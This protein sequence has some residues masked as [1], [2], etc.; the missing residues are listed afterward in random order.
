MFAGGE[1][2][3]Q[4]FLCGLKLE[5]R[6]STTPVVSSATATVSHVWVISG[7]TEEARIPRRFWAGSLPGFMRSSAV[8][9]RK[10][11]ASV[12]RMV[13]MVPQI[14]RSIPVPFSFL[15]PPSL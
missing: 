13:K 12:A 1:G 9:L 8:C 10:N 4:E 11:M 3:V 2:L 14:I 6:D 15:L 5:N 7:K